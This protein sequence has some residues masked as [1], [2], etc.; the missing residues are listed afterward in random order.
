MSTYKDIAKVS[1]NI[2]ATRAVGTANSSNPLPIIIPCH[3]V[4]ASS[5][6][7]GGY[8]YGLKMKKKLLKLE[9]HSLNEPLAF[10]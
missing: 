10:N 5:G 3:R 7:I 1:G 8:A 6:Y 2:N 9:G 4:I